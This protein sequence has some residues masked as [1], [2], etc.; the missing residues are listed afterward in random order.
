[1]TLIRHL[2]RSSRERTIIDFKKCP[3]INRLVSV[4]PI[5]LCRGCLHTFARRCCRR[6][7]G[8]GE[9]TCIKNVVFPQTLLWGGCGAGGDGKSEVWLMGANLG[10]RQGGRQRAWQARRALRW[11]CP[12]GLLVGSR[13]EEMKV[14]PAQHPAVGA[15]CATG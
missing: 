7:W 15:A 1:M 14:A 5:C 8:V 9:R 10:A 6:P 4:P 11:R 12:G 13:Q 3:T 2:F